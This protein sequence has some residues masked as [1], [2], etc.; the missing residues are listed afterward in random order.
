MNSLSLLHLSLIKNIGPGRIEKLLSHLPR[1]ADIYQMTVHDFSGYGITMQTAQTVVDGLKDSS[2][3]Q[4]ELERIEKHS[5]QWATLLDAHYPPLLKEIH[6]PPPVIYWKGVLPQKETTVAL[7]GSR[8]ANAYGRRVTKSI[9]ADLVSNGVTTVSGG[10]YGIDTCVHHATLEAGGQTIAVLGSGLLCP[11]PATNRRLFESIAQ[12]GGAVMSSFPLLTEA[13]PGNFPARNRIISGL[14][15]ACVVV[16]AAEKSGALI[17]AKYALEQGRGVCAIPGSIDDPLSKG[18]HNLLA[19]GARVV[20]GAGDIF[21]ELGYEP[22]A[23]RTTELKEV[24][25]LLVLC[26]HPIGFDELTEKAGI[27]EN[28]LKEKLFTLQL[29]GKIEQDFAGLWQRV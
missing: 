4:Q 13:L 28:E 17:T 23:E 5:I 15:V 20:Q 1:E 14:S 9:V 21:E 16:Q 8:A 3:L 10:A 22:G 26:A 11:Y 25:P 29:E 7:V 24:D 18:C 2:L 27:S 12:E 19:S 6:L